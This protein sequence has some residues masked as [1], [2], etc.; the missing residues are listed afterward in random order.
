MRME[1]A[2]QVKGRVAMVTGGGSGIGRATALM[3]AREGADL[4]ICDIDQAAGER[5]CAE[6]EA[7]GR[8]AL[9]LATDSSDGS[10]VRRLV[11]AGAERFGKIDILVNNAGIAHQATIRELTEELWDRVIA[12]HLRS[13][14]V[15]TQ[16]AIEHMIPGNWGRIVNIVSRAAFK[17][18]A[19]IGPYAAAKGGMLAYARVLAVE[20]AQWG[21]TVNNI[22]PGTTLTPLV[23]KG[24]TTEEMRAEE[25]RSSGVITRPPRLAEADEMAAA[26]LYLCGLYSSHVT[27]TTMHVNGGSYMP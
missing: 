7:I 23:M 1:E 21:I 26:V 8:G 2:M 4:I 14:F 20:T 19:G 6:V 10:A 17:G 11:Q 25:A 9:A 3:L 18:R 15:C 24:F 5:V 27:G 13:M 16:A 12:V 22:A